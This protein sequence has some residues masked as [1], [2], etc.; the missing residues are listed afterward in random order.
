MTREFILGTAGHIDHGKTSL[1]KALTDIDTDSLAEEKR[2]GMSIDLGFAHAEIGVSPQGEPLTLGFVDVPGHERFVRN[3]LAGVAAIDLALLVVAADDGVMPQTREH[4]S[5]LSLLGVPRC[6]VALTKVDR[7]A[8]ERLAQARREV[9]DLLATAYAAAPLF[10]LVAT[11]PGDAGV[12]ALRQ[13][14]ADEAARLAARSLSGYFRLVVDRSFALAGAGRIV[15]GAVLSGRVQVGDELVLSPHGISARVRSLQVGKQRTEQALAGQRC[16]IN[17]AGVDLKRRDP[18]RGDWLLAPAAHAPTDRLDVQLRVLASESRPLPSRQMLQLH[19]GAAA[20]NARVAALAGWD[21]APGSSGLAQLVL[22]SPVAA[23]HGDRFVLRD[24]SVSRTLAGGQVVDPFGPTRGRDRPARVLQL[25]A[26]AL[27]EPAQAL[28]ALLAVEPGGV[29][30]VRFALTRNLRDDEA[31]AL[32]LAQSVQRVAGSAWGL[33]VGH[34]Q[35][36]RE[37]LCEALARWHADQPDLSGVAA[38]VLAPVLRTV[39]LRAALDSLV[40]AGTVRRDGLRYRLAGH[41]AELSEAD[42]D[43]LARVAHCLAPGGLRPPIV[44]E[45]AALLGLPQPALVEFLG[46][47]HRLGHL[48][49]VAPNRFYLPPTVAELARHARQLAAES[50]DGG[51]DAAAYRDRTGIGRNLAVQVLE[52]LD[53]EGLTRFDGIR[54]QPVD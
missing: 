16:A 2:R 19:I 46:R 43:L 40:Q 17:L 35:A 29:D 30:L 38:A 51:V 4:L 49:R 52:F 11:D 31:D 39:L 7:V 45:L 41:S 48:V 9:A 23:L 33:S 13:H 28:A 25:A 8:P 37:R 50:A 5:I 44:G 12:L 27:P 1:V 32:I 15:T 22:E 26:L 47:A 21:A 18:V 54:H 14:L 42:A 36:L 20:I 34:W 24:P 3:M 53:R 10:P 6:A